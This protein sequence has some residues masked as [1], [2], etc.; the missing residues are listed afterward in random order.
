MGLIPY[1]E[2]V[3]LNAIAVSA[4]FVTSSPTVQ[5]QGLSMWSMVSMDVVDEDAWHGKVD[6]R[7]YRQF[8]SFTR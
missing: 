7:T 6:L 4:T 3:T 5:F 1:S 2:T 8:A